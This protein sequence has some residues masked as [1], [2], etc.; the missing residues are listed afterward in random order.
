M[1]GAVLGCP[2][3]EVSR[4]ARTKWLAAWVQRRLNPQCSV[5]S[6]HGFWNG[7]GLLVSAEVQAESVLRNPRSIC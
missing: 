7:S 5:K 4:D 1:A 3:Y 2:W 6:T